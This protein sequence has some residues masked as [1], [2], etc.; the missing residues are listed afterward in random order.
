MYHSYVYGVGQ[1]V[2]GDL[3]QRF[4][5]HGLHDEVLIEFNQPIVDLRHHHPVHRWP[6]IIRAEAGDLLVAHEHERAALD[7]FRILPGRRGIDWLHAISGKQVEKDGSGNARARGE[8]E[9]LPA[10]GWTGLAEHCGE[11]ERATHVCPSCCVVEP[12]SMVTDRR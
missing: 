5:Q 8:L 2:L 3:R 6:R 1:A 4:G 10:S 7:R 12:V 11:I 9:E